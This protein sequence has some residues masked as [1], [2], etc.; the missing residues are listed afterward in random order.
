MNRWD[1]IKVLTGPVI[2]AAIAILAIWAKEFFERRKSIQTWF[3]EQY[4]FQGVDLLIAQFILLESLLIDYQHI[5]QTRIPRML[6]KSP[7]ELPPDVIAKLQ[8]ILN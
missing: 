5:E 4:I 6:S 7:D 8:A 2:G 1:T 3:E